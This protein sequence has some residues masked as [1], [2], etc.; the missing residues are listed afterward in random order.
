[1]H[2]PAH[3]CVIG[4]VGTVG[5]SI[6]VNGEIPCK[7]GS[8]QSR[9][10]AIVLIGF[11]SPLL[12]FSHCE[13]GHDFEGPKFTRSCISGDFTQVEITGFGHNVMLQRV[14]REDYLPC[15]H[16]YDVLQP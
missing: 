6:H 7:V 5:T 13:L 10:K 2:S 11:F 14:F 12:K 8:Y 15:V 16:Y 9:P 3:I 1:M 4:V